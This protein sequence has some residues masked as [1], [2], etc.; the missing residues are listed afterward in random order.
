MSGLAEHLAEDGNSSDALRELA[1]TER[2]ASK[3]ENGATED[4]ADAFATGFMAGLHFACF[5]A[6]HENDD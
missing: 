4:E 3:L 1:R 5:G 6:S 2:D